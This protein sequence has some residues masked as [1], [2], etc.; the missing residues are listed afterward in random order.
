MYPIFKTNRPIV[1]A[2]YLYSEC[3]VKLILK[4]EGL[5]KQYYIQEE[6]IILTSLNFCYVYCNSIIID[7]HKIS[8]IAQPYLEQN[9]NNKN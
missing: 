2:Y 4:N 6:V 8:L 7:L 1:C 3:N 9:S 5:E